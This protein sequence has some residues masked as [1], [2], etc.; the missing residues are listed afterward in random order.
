MCSKGDEEGN[1]TDDA[2]SKGDEEVDEKDDVYSK[3]FFSLE[4]I[5]EELKKAEQEE[6]VA[7]L[8]SDAE[9]LAQKVLR[10][11]GECG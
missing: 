2:C 7:A 6:W 5:D 9:L 8:I 10:D 4:E 11:L 3:G 1:E